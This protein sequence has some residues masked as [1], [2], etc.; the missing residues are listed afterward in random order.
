MPQQKLDLVKIPETPFKAYKGFKIVKINGQEVLKSQYGTE[1]WG[2][3]VCRM[4]GGG[5]IDMWDKTKSV[6][7][8]YENFNNAIKSAIQIIKR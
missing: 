6:K 1:M 7:D 2:Y 5:I 4:R 8:Y 3:D